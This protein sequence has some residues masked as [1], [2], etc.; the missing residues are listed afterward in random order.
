MCELHGRLRS[1]PPLNCSDPEPFSGVDVIAVRIG[2]EAELTAL[3][4]SLPLALARVAAGAKRLQAC[5]R[6]APEMIVVDEAHDMIGLGCRRGLPE[7]GA[8]LA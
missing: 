2:T 5:P 6:R 8:V 7:K 1:A 3:R 4:A